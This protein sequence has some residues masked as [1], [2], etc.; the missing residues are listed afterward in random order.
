MRSTRS[1]AL[2]LA[3]AGALALTACGGSSGS[4]SG[5]DCVVKLGSVFST[6][7]AAAA[8]GTDGQNSIDM[9][10]KDINATGFTVAGRKCTF[11]LKA[12][13]MASNPDNMARNAQDLITGFG[14]HYLIGGDMSPAI[15]PMVTA[16]ERTGNVMALSV[17]TSMQNYVKPDKPFFKLSASDD[18]MVNNGY[19]PAVAKALPGVKRIA[20]LMN[21]D[22]TGRALADSYVPAFAQNGVT[23]T[24]KIFFDPAA[25]DFATVVNQ[26]PR[27]SVDGLFIGYNSDGRAAAIMDAALDAGLTKNF[28]TRGISALPGQQRASKIDNYAWL[29][30]GADP[31]YPGTDKVKDFIGRYAKTY[32]ED[33]AKVTWFP[34]T[35]YDYIAMLAQA[36]EKAGTTD[37]VGKVAAALR[38]M[39]YDGV[40]RVSFDATG[41]NTSPMGAGVLTSSGGQV[42]PFG[43]S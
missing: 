31:A 23:V 39:S 36:M 33:P 6:T 7:G 41:A 5:G 29:V 21:N 13:D 4:G 11:E 22:D 2:G 38:G 34:F 35:H 9:A 28:I 26:V 15:P 1:A 17:T 3:L 42:I 27:G 12:A 16:A 43:I 30:L 32:N 37:D 20:M 24:Q 14:A 18:K 19:I 10:V 8:F 40:V 25:T